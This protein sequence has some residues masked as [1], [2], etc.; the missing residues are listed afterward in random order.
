MW[1]NIKSYWYTESETEHQK[2]K[3]TDRNRIN[4]A[5]LYTAEHGKLCRYFGKDFGHFSKML[6]IK[7][8]HDAVHT[9]N[10]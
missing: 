1:T 6:N 4:S 10:I 2:K 5:S 3:K 7:L 9:Q 8:P